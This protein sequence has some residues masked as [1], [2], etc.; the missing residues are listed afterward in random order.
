MAR[1]KL[2]RKSFGIAGAIGGAIK[3]IKPAAKVG[4]GVAGAGALG[5]GAVAY[6]AGGGDL[7]SG[8]EK[9]AKEMEF[10]ASGYDEDG[11]RTYKFGLKGMFGMNKL[12][13]EKPNT[14]DNL[15]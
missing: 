10:S 15:I 14:Q 11:N 3:A 2:K 6:K 13:K 7:I 1:F 8:G 12:S 9:S 5:A 4:L